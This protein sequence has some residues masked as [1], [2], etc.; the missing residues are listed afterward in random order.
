MVIRLIMNPTFFLSQ[1]FGLMFYK[2]QIIDDKI[3]FTK[4]RTLIFYCFIL[5]VNNLI[6]RYV[7]TSKVDRIL[8]LTYDS[9]L[10][11]QRIHS[12]V[13]YCFLLIANGSFLIN[14][15][16]ICAI[17]KNFDD[18][19][20]FLPFPENY[21]RVEKV[22]KYCYYTTLLCVLFVFIQ[23]LFF[24]SVISSVINLFDGFWYVFNQL[25][26]VVQYVQY[27]TFVYGASI[28]FTIINKTIIEKWELNEDRVRCLVIADNI[29]KDVADEIN[30]IFSVRNTLN[31]FQLAL[32]VVILVTAY[33]QKLQTHFN[34]R[35][36]LT[37]FFIYQVNAIVIQSVLTVKKVCAVA[38]LEYAGLISYIF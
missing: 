16:C 23:D 20:I 18:F 10:L 21:K 24:F 12:S 9:S 17:Y 32:D 36:S 3:T 13:S 8:E 11:L 25:I 35:S 26:Q 2:L 33:F 28:L 19:F 27:V 38:Q 1:I 22:R 31:V 15:K 34:I 4:S 5:Y 7:M 14:S 29:S 37:F 30:H 6:S